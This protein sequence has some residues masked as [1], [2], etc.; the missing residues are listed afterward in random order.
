[1]N[2]K[3][4][5]IVRVLFGIMLLVFGSF[6]FMNLPVP[7]FYSGKARD[8]LLA[9]SATGYL[10]YAVGIIFII[11][12]LLF[13]IGRFVALGTVLLAPVIVN[14]LLFHIFLD[15]KSIFPLPLVFAILELFVAY[16]V[17]EKYRA[18]FE[19]I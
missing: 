13:V 4:I 12:G 6:S 3:L 18:L 2:K 15:F 1:M 14:I 5:L 10:T 16:S 11:V 7:D 8:F 17:R 19:A 9:M